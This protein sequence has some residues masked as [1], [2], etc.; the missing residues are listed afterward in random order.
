VK[1]LL[2]LYHEMV[3][4]GI[5][6]DP[7]TVDRCVFVCGSFPSDDAKRLLDDIAEY[8]AET[9]GNSS[10]RSRALSEAMLKQDMKELEGSV[11]TH[12]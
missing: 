11:E 5:P 4:Q 3:A 9:V 12:N 8:D 1:E 10:R 6:R 2:Q 7:R